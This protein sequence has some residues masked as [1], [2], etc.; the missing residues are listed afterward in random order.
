MENLLAYLKFRNQNKKAWMRIVEAFIAIILIMTVM[1]VVIQRQRLGSNSLEEIQIKQ[2]N[3]LNLVAR[4]EV[5]RGELLSW[6]AT[7]TNEKIKYLVPTGYNYSIELCRY[8]E[9]CNLNFTVPADV[10]SDETLIVANLTHYIPDEA[11]KLKLFFWRGPFPEGQQPH[12][13]SEPLYVPEP[14]CT[15][16]ADCTSIQFCEIISHTCQPGIAVLQTSFGIRESWIA[17]N[18]KY[19]NWTVTISTSHFDW[20]ADGVVDCWINVPTDLPWSSNCN[21]TIYTDRTRNATIAVP[22][23]RTPTTSIISKQATGNVYNRTYFGHDSR[24][25]S[26][27]TSAFIVIPFS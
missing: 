4:D 27:N 2:K 7:Q 17:S 6:Q 1:L 5:L 3:I 22:F 16:S 26:V 13:Y 25:N 12:N 18:R 19:I 23:T 8:N 20:Y 14:E 10:F 21:T 24:G 15:S 11:V 9:I